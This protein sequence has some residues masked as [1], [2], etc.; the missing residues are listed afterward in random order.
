M[1]TRYEGESVPLR[2]HFRPPL[3]D[4]HSWDGLHGGWPMMIVQQLIKVLP[5]R[6]FALPGVYL[7]SLFEVDIG[8]FR[9]LE[10]DSEGPDSGNGGS[11]VATYTSP[12]PTLT[13]E[14]KL[15][16]QD[17]YEVRIYDGRRN[18]ELV[19]AIELVSPSN[20]DRPENREAFVGKSAELLKNGI[21]V[22]IVDI[23]GT[24][25]FNL[26]AEL[27]DAVRGVD[28]ALGSEPQPMYAVTLRTRLEGRRKMMD[29][30][31]QPLAI[32]QKLPTLPIWLTK[33]LA[34]S[35]ELES[36]YEETCRTLRIR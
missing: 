6:Y 32:G 3:D 16:N 10:S 18:R 19:A 21:C 28:P 30:W 9:N 31:Y 17:V 12:K 11:G 5:E 23:V 1:Y 7:G 2:D 35:L 29:T 33:T 22:S 24:L 25:N 8:S 26:Y 27:M 34:V 36:S 20:K 15:P 13:L 4:V 14:P